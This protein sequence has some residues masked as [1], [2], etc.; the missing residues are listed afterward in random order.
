MNFSE[1]KR[2]QL[3]F[4]RYPFSVGIYPGALQPNSIGGLDPSR[5][6]TIATELKKHNYSTAAVGTNRNLFE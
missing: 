6:P 3:T 5:F 2:G 4:Y 1:C